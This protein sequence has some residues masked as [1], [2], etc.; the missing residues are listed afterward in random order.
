MDKDILKKDIINKIKEYSKYLEKPFQPGISFI[1]CSG[2]KFDSEELIN[3]VEAV[4]DGWWTEGRFSEEFSNKI[5]KFLPIKHTILTNS[6]SSSNLLAIMSLTSKE[7]P[8]DKRLKK[9]DEIITIAAG[10]PTTINSI[11]NANCIPVFIDVKLGTYNIDTDFLEQAYSNKTKAV[12]LAHTLGNPF[13]INK[14]KKFC[15]KYNL[16]LI[17]DCCDALGSLY[18]DKHVG[19][20]G[21]ISTFSFYPA[22]HITTGEGGAICTNDETLAKIITSFRDWGRDCWCG[23]GHDNTCNKRFSQ[24]H[25]N[26][27]FGY[28]HKYVYSHLGYNMKLTDMQAAIGVAQMD[29]LSSFIETRENNFNKFY[30]YFKEYKD[31]FILPESELNAKPSWFGFPLTIKDNK[32]SRLELLNYLTKNK[33]GTRLLFGG[34]IIKQPYFI[35]YNFGYRI[36]NE[37]KNTDY[38]MNNFFWI[39][40][41]PALNQEMINYTIKVFNN[42]INNHK[43]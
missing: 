12:F 5:S 7:I 20:F 26:L 39:G 6:G 2:K 24:K 25:G 9:G 36:I 15:K 23:T 4:L 18:E 37:L 43:F 8:E 27:P 31:I 42:F 38:I 14:I 1:P 16:W 32:F 11:I 13:N 41:Q 34:N 29:K 40:I 33:I 3:G 10:F 21:D 28:D 30:D 17:E 35:D 22:H 19:T